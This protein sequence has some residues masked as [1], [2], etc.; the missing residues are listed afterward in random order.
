MEGLVSKIELNNQELENLP[1]FFKIIYFNEMSSLEDENKLMKFNKRINAVQMRHY[2][3]N[4]II[5]KSINTNT[6]KTQK[7]E[8]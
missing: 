7:D 6:F 5:C 2:E 1:M 3:P 8:L 4:R